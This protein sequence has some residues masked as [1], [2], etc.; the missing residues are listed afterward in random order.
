MN[1]LT[2]TLRVYYI[3]RNREIQNYKHTVEMN[4]ASPQ[5]EQTGVNKDLFSKTGFRWILISVRSIQAKYRFLQKTS[6]ILSALIPVISFQASGRQDMTTS[7]LVFLT[8]QSPSS[9][10]P[11]G[12]GDPVVDQI[13]HVVRHTFM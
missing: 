5:P 4:Y 8:Q 3:T 12:H 1:G 6:Y 13:I 2:S 11:Y 7:F 10:H 9:C